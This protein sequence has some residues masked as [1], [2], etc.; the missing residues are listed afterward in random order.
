M[1]TITLQLLAF[2]FTYWVASDVVCLVALRFLRPADR[3]SSWEIFLLTRGLGPIVISWLVF[4]LLLFAPQCRPSVYIAGVLSVFALG[5]GLGRR[6]FAELARIYGG[7]WHALPRC[8]PRTASGR[9]LLIVALALAV[10]M[11]SIGIGFPI[12]ASDSLGFAIEARL[13][14]RDLSFAHYPPLVADALTGY[15]YPTFQVPCLQSLYVWFFLLTRTTDIDILLRTVAPVYALYCGL[16]VFWVLF[17]RTRNVDTALWGVIALLA[18]PVFIVHSYMNNQD[19]HRIYFSFCVLLCLTTLLQS[20]TKANAVALGVFVGFAI[21]AHFF[22]LVTAAVV[23]ALYTLLS[24]QPLRMRLA[25]LLLVVLVAAPL[26]GFDHYVVSTRNAEQTLAGRVLRQFGV[27]RAT[28]ADAPGADVSAAPSNRGD[29]WLLSRRGQGGGAFKQWV[30]GVLQPF[31]GIEWF[32]A[33]FWLLVVALL[34]WGRRSEKTRLETVMA[35]TAVAYLAVVLSGVRTLSW[36]NP[37]YAGT[38]API[39]AYFTGLLAVTLHRQGF[40]RG[41]ATRASVRLVALIVV[42]VVPLTLTTCV[43]GAKVGITNPGDFYEQLHSTAWIRAGVRDPLGSLRTLFE[44]YF[45]GLQTVRYAW[46]SD[47]EKLLHAHDYFRAVDYMNRNTPADA[48]GLVI[49]REA[50]YFYYAERHGASLADPQLGSVWL[51]TDPVEVCAE[52][53]GRGIHYVLIDSF[54]Q[55]HPSYVGTQ[56]P[57]IVGDSALA[58]LVFEA[59]TARVYRLSCDGAAATAGTQALHH[60]DVRWPPNN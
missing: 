44:R 24:Q 45:G 2:L 59:G 56:L 22:G 42:F 6:Q 55:N 3:D 49:G 7:V 34:Y 47:H 46:A 31:T 12:V 36:S 19:A 37:R 15:Y 43:R 27:T 8:W 54:Y 58:T 52:L 39:V 20:A 13:I 33:F 14:Y 16:M 38:L 18:L 25:R 41:D 35:W 5:G 48:T 60:S 51:K 4:Q 26:S 53:V 50:Y 28:P 11:L 17:R 9:V 29:D 21:Y 57:A 30:F 32:G 23:L 40:G 10:F 1:Q